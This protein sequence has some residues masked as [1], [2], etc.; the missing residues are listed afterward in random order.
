MKTTVNPWSVRC[1]VSY[2]QSQSGI[3]CCNRLGFTLANPHYQRVTKATK[4]V[5]KAQRQRES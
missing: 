1:P 5:N 3:K 4:A 2:C